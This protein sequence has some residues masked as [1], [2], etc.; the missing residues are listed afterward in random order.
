MHKRFLAI[1]AIVAT[2]FAFGIGSALADKPE[3]AGKKSPH[4]ACEKDDPPEGCED[5]G[6][7]D[8]PDGDDDDDGEDPPGDGSP[9]D[10]LCDALGAVD[11]ALAD[12]CQQVVDALTG[13]EAPEFPPGDGGGEPG[14][15]PSC[16]DIPEPQ[17]ADGCQQVVDAIG[18]GEAP[19][20]G[21]QPSCADL[22]APE[23][24]AG[25]QDLLDTIGVPGL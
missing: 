9:L 5:N 3:D 11:P 23:L 13:G 10:A 7:P 17:L 8:D 4:P 19:Q 22:P 18:G 16:A 2:I 21:G 14:G 24:A 25:C 12:V 6:H 1:L 15:E 20:P